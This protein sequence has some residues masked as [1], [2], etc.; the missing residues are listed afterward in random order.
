[1]KRKLFWITPKWP[2]PAED[3]ARRATSHLLKSLAQHGVDI[4]LCAI[5]PE[6]ERP[7]TRQAIEELGVKGVSV[8][9]RTPSKKTTHLMNLI[10]RPRMPL[11]VS[12]YATRTISAQI[13]NALASHVDRSLVFDGLHAAGWLPYCTSSLR[14]SFRKIYR[15]HNVESNLWVQGAERSKNKAMSWFL[16]YQASRMHA[17]ERAICRESEL[18]AAVSKDDEAGLQK[19]YGPIITR[20]IPIGI[21]IDHEV[22]KSS[23]PSERKLLFIGRLDWQPNKEGLSWFL[24]NVW[25]TASKN[26]PDLSLTI[27]GAGDGRW[28]ERFANLPRVRFM[29]RVAEVAPLY[30]EAAAALAP[31]FFGSGTRVK[32]IEASAFGRPCISTAIGVEGIGLDEKTSYFRAENSDEWLCA[33][34][35]LDLAEAEKR[36]KNAFHLIAQE[37]D[38]V[39]IASRFLED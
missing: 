36:G 18:V 30:K 13:E 32:A 38:P 17:F 4:H 22:L 3:G 11:T 5:V 6:N 16:S 12:P 31:V 28:L 27:A 33:L 24:E 15:A 19:K 29:G 10:S 25:S 35:T 26:S 34:S 7:D 1:M 14:N 2:L 8:V 9:H 39:R 21:P 23:F 37:F 20:N